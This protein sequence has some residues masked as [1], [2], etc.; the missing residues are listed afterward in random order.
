M[1]PPNIIVSIIAATEE[2]TI[3]NIVPE[4]S[5]I[6]DRDDSIREYLETDFD[7]ESTVIRILRAFLANALRDVHE[8]RE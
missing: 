3:K 1:W 6:V 8:N 4:I 5:E 2:A 7:V